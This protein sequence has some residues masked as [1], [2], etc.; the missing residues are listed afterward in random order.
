MTASGAWIAGRVAGR[1]ISPGDTEMRRCR[2]SAAVGASTRRR[3]RRA[4][5]R[6]S[7]RRAAD[8]RR[9]LRAGVEQASGRRPTTPRRRAAAPRAAALELLGDANYEIAAGARATSADAPRR[10]VVAA[11]SAMTPWL[12]LGEDATSAPDLGGNGARRGSR[13]GRRRRRRAGCRASPAATTLGLAIVRGTAGASCARATPTSCVG[14]ALRR[15]RSPGRPCGDHRASRPASRRRSATTC[16]SGDACERA[17][18]R[19][20]TRAPRDRATSEPACAV[21]ALR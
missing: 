9:R 7:T 8:H 18:E 15:E 5:S 1:V 10:R 20:T 14:S 16:C 13:A 6:P 2:R 12:S 4:T 17:R 11:A 21:S 19:A 3:A